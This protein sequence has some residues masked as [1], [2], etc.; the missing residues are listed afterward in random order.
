[1][2]EQTK[3]WL[4]QEMKD[5][6]QLLKQFRAKINKRVPVWMAISVA[7]MFL[8]G[9]LVGYDIT[10]VLRVHFVIGCGIAF[11]IWF[12]FWLQGRATSAKKARKAYEKAMADFFVSDEDQ[13]AFNRQM[14]TQN[15][16]TVNFL[17]ITTDNYPCRFLAGPDYWIYFKNGR[18][19]FIRTAD[20]ARVY[21]QEETSRISYNVGNRRVRQNMSVG[22]SLVI[23]YK[24]ES[25]SAQKQK[26]DKLFTENQTQS[27]AVTELIRKHS[28][29]IPGVL[30]A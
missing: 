18:C 24:E 8:L 23:E 10:Y 9:I 2:N 17:T 15:Y 14:D 16:G 28:L 4:D 7:A 25:P 3:L 19:Q 21:E 20:I 30:H 11:F 22:V 26:E 1:M 27:N 13:A 5:F 12:C 29:Q 6:S